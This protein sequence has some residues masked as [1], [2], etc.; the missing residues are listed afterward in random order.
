MTAGLIITTAIA[1]TAC[2]KSTASFDTL[3]MGTET[4]VED[5]GESL[6][7]NGDE[8][9]TTKTS[10][11]NQTKETTK[12]SKDTKE[13]TSAASGKDSSS[14]TTKAQDAS[15]PQDTQ[16]ETT[17]QAEAD[18]QSVTTQQ[19]DTTPAQTEPQTEAEK[20]TEKHTE[21]ATKAHTHSYSQTVT[22]EPTCTSEGTRTFTCDCGDTYTE[23]IP[24][25][26]HNFGS[27]TYNNDATENSDGT[28][29]AKC[30]DCEEKDTRTAAGTKLAHTHSYSAKVTKEATCSEVGVTTYTCSCGDSYTESIPTTGHSFGDYVYNND[31]T[32]DA[33]GT[34]TRYCSVCGT[35]ETV[36]AEGTKKALPSWYDEHSEPLN[37]ATG[38]MRDGSLEMYFTD[39]DWT[40]V[41]DGCWAF[42][43]GSYMETVGEYAEGW[44]HYGYLR[45]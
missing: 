12:A 20:Q 31:A 45:K 43:Y 2:S 6:V 25:T 13:T 41:S 44:V 39:G 42:G 33:D 22:K 11:K 40:G 9:E 26:G 29:T 10:D 37:V 21:A 19:E 24:A 7:S 1:A 16:P 23:S 14:S 27:Y 5:S 3:P 15:H 4:P 28:E 34:K 17:T 32:K 35:S 18:T 38:G 30:S 36:T 8:K